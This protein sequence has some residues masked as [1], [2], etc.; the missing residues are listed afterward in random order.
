MPL[1][2]QMAEAT[3]LEGRVKYNMAVRAGS[4]GRLFQ[5][6]T[7]FSPNINIVRDPRWGRG[8]ETYGED[9]YL[10]G[11]LG[12]AFI[13]GLQGDD[14]KHLTAVATAKYYA[15]NDSKGSGGGV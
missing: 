10:T 3:A 8:Q 14:P 6:L 13:T 11:K 1:L 15:R 5:G 12:V 2:H 4:R 9:P 7:F